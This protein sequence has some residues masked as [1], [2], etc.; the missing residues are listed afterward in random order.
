MVLRDLVSER[1]ATCG[2][3]LRGLG[4]HGDDE[5]NDLEVRILMDFTMGDLA[6]S[7]RVQ[8]P[9]QDRINRE[10]AS[11]ADDLGMGKDTGEALRQL[12]RDR[13]ED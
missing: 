5:N 3:Y 6:F 2:I 1:L 10:A 8:N 9:A 7:P 13:F 4:V 12:W 11:M